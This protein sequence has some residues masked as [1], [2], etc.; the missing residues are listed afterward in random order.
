MLDA[1]HRDVRLRLITPGE[2]FDAETVRV[3]SRG[4]WGPLL[5][6]GAEIYEY[7]PTRYRCK[8]IIDRLMISVASTNF[9]NRS[10]R[11][12][13][14][15]NPVIYDPAFSQRQAQVFKADLMRARRVSLKDWE[16]RPLKENFSERL[17]LLLGSQI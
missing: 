4:M 8:V 17:A 14:E 10:F 6:A 16:A 5:A 7:Q 15:A 11:M 13:D 2:I 3:T 1:M 9:D 12:N